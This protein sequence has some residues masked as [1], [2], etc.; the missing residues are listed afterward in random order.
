NESTVLM[1]V[2]LLLI[3]IML[4]PRV[5]PSYT[6]VSIHGRKKI[7]FVFISICFSTLCNSSF[8]IIFR[9]CCPV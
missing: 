1:F 3:V 8:I 2:V 5:S 4:C 7:C 6:D 9:L